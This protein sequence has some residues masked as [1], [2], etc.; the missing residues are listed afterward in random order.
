MIKK[1]SQNRAPMDPESM[2]KPLGCRIKK[3]P[4]FINPCGTQKLS[5]SIKE[6]Q[7]KIDKNNQLKNISN[8]KLEFEL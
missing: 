2:K 1:G 5:I 7:I 6:I 8:N 4:K 3:N